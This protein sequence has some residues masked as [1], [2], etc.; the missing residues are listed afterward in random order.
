MP[1]TTVEEFYN[2]GWGDVGVFLSVSIA[3]GRVTG[4]ALLNK[5]HVDKNKYFL[6]AVVFAMEVFRE[7]VE[8]DFTLEDGISIL[9][10]VTLFCSLEVLV[11][12]LLNGS[13]AEV[14]HRRTVVPG[15]AVGLIIG[16]VNARLGGINNSG[17]FTQRT[18]CFTNRPELDTSRTNSLIQHALSECR[19]SQ[20]KPLE[21]S[22]DVYTRMCERLHFAVTGVKN[23]SKMPLGIQHLEPTTSSPGGWRTQSSLLRPQARLR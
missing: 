19:R 21:A 9:C 7:Q 11:H 15:G 18:Q 2:Y 6:S 13:L 14:W 12:V 10:T 23:R 4:C 22:S 20:E 17:G 5:A 16:L 8:D 3:T 1:C